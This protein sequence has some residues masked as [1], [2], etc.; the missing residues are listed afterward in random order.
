MEKSSTLVRRI[1]APA[2]WI[3]A[4]GRSFYIDKPDSLALSKVGVD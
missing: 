4:V 3:A 1:G 2:S